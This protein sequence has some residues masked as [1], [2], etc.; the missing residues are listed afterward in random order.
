MRPHMAARQHNIKESKMGSYQIII[1]IMVAFLL[2]AGVV[3]GSTLDVKGC[4]ELI[5]A[6]SKQ[7]GQQP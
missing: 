2:G 7:E 4:N 6:M 3:A 5:D 1:S